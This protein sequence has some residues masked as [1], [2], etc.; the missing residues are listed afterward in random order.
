[1]LDGGGDFADGVIA[2]E[3]EW[4][5]A[6]EFVSFDPKAVSISRSAGTRARFSGERRIAKSEERVTGERRFLWLVLEKLPLLVLS[7]ASAWITVVAQRSDYAVRNLQEFPFA[8]RA[9][10]ALVAYSLY[11]WKMLWPSRLALLYP[12]PASALPIG[13]V[14]LSGLV[15]LAISALVVIFRDKRYLATGW[16][17]FLGTLVPVIGLVQVGEGAMADRYAYLPLIG[18]FIMIAWS[19]D[20]WY[21][22]RKLSTGWKLVPAF[23]ALTALAIVT[24][25]QIGFW[26]SEYGIWAH[27]VAVTEPNPF[28]EAVL[29]AALLNPDV[30]MSARDIANFDTQQKRL[31][32]A[33]RHYEQALT[34][35]RELIQQSPSTY[36]PDMAALSNLGDVARLEDRP[37]EARQH[38]EEALQY[39]RQLELQ[40]PAPHLANIATTLT[41]LAAVERRLGRN[42]D[43]EQCDEQA[44]KVYRQLAQQDPGKYLPKMVDTLI[45]LGFTARLLK[46]PDQ[47]YPYFNEALSVGRQLAKQDPAA[48]LPKLAGRLI[49]LGNFDKEQ[50][51]LEEARQHYGEALQIFG[52]LSA[53]N[54]AA[55][56]AEMLSALIIWELWMQCRTASPTH[57]GISSRRWR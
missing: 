2:Y 18:I 22:A 56:R 25:H 7:A 52:E 37:E 10:N 40:N 49:N 13:E 4:L 9:E 54:P 14:A 53:S 50:N 42:Q 47:A 41:Y 51:R 34:S 17:W 57:A 6:E 23:C 15:L 12:H 46:Q 11:L 29:A 20:D 32:E 39:Y 26:E 1:M 31:D 5:G 8:V 55:Y 30:A 33:R 3:G 45:D 24:F 16:C 38:Y 28:A 48:Y 36:M 21:Q 19:L 35:Y 27:T 43:A 44:L